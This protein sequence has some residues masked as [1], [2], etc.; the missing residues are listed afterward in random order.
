MTSTKFSRI[1]LYRIRYRAYRHKYGP[2]RA[3]WRGIVLSALYLYS[4]SILKDERELL[5]HLIHAEA[6]SVEIHL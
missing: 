4:S 5:P 6:I 2:L 3:F 1:K